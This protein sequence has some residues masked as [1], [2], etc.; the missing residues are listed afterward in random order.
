MFIGLINVCCVGSV[1][2]QIEVYKNV[3]VLPICGKRGLTFRAKALP[4]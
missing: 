1:E 3:D 4:R 2:I